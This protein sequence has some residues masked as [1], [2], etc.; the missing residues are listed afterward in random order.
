MRRRRRRRRRRRKERNKG[1]KDK[2]GS[3]LSSVLGPVFSTKAERST[4][5]LKSG[6][7]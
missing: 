7:D 1:K 6:T 2:I 4:E 3:P 5:T